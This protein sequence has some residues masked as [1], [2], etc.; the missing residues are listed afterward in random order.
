MEQMP[1]DVFVPQYGTLQDG[2]WVKKKTLALQKVE[3]NRFR[4]GPLPE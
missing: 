2:R 1:F 3:N 4:N